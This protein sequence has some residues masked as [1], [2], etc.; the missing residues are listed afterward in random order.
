MVTGQKYP[1]RLIP[2]A[3]FFL[4]VVAI[5]PLS[6]GSRPRPT[7]TPILQEKLEKYTQELDK[8]IGEMISEVKRLKAAM[9][10][11]EF[12]A[13]Q[14]WMAVVYFPAAYELPPWPKELQES[15]RRFSPEDSPPFPSPR[16]LKYSTLLDDIAA[17]II[18]KYELEALLRGEVEPP[19]DTGGLSKEDWWNAQLGEE[20]EEPPEG[21]ATSTPSF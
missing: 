21:G 14:K 10:A 9:P 1:K 4:V 13:G 7:P 15:E 8:R 20:D 17:L 16:Y 2:L 6:C 5:S 3:I 18:D 11:E 19:P 12:E